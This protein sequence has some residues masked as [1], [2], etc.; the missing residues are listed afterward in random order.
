M[1]VRTSESSTERSK[2][3]F[4]ILPMLMQATYERVQSCKVHTDDLA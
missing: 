2:F 1:E 4:A 3:L